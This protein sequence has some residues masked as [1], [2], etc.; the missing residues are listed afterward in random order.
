[1]LLSKVISNK[2]IRIKALPVRRALVSSGVMAFAGMGDAVLYPVLP[3]YA[4]ELGL[5]IISVGILLSIN[6]FARIFTTTWV[7]NI[8]NRVGMKNVLFISS[9]CA[10]ITTLLYGLELGLLSF[11][12]A[13]IIWGLSYSGLKITTLN[14]ASQVKK[15]SGLIFGVTQSIKSLGALFALWLGP[16]LIQNYGINKGLFVI[17]CISVIALLLVF[18]IP[19]SNFT[20]RHIVKSKIT[21]SLTPINVL[22]GILALSIDGILVVVLANLLR[23]TIQNSEELLIIVAGYLFMKRLFMTAISVVIGF[24]SIKISSHKI[25]NF[26]VIVSIISLLLIAFNFIVLGIITAFI[27]NTIVVTFSPLVAINQDEND[28]SLQAV[29]SVSTWWDLGAG[30]GAFIGILLFREIGQTYLFLTLFSISA[31]LFTNFTIQNG[32]KNRAII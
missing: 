4:N 9:I 24:L 8:I 26:S 1:M 27:F 12:I 3:V 19:T 7:A 17:A 28:N 13:R 15:N 21:F 5:P 30:T 31:L 18:L 10:V 14:Y 6:R 20:S 11:V 25:F 29:S 23:A 2:A 32:K 22:V 16:I